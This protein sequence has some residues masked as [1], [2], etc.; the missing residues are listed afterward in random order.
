MNF[1][2]LSF[3][4]VRLFCAKD[5]KKDQTFF[6]S[7]VTQNALRKTMFPLGNLSKNEV[8]QI[9]FENGLEKIARKKESMG[10]CFIG[11]RNFQ[12][13]IAEVMFHNILIGILNTYKL[14]FLVH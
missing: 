6:L 13:F 10:I 3:V 9:A 4:A 14:Y 2:F 12:N 8:K 5:T 1:S 7:Q 11:F